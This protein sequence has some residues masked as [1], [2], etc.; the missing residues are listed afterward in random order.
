VLE[1]DGVDVDEEEVPAAPAPLPPRRR[2][3]EHAERVG[4]QHEPVHRERAPLLPDHDPHRGG[5]FGG[6]QG[7][8]SE[9]GVRGRRP[10]EEDAAAAGHLS[11]RK[12][13]RALF[14][15][16]LLL[17]VSACSVFWKEA[18]SFIWME[19]RRAGMLNEPLERFC[20]TGPGASENP[21]GAVCGLKHG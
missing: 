20:G 4:V 12:L 1:Q 21:L 3:Q 9:A 16:L 7:A 10:P 11:R 6:I 15:G 18:K 13:A 14:L 5:V 19:E 2:L 17:T 8:V